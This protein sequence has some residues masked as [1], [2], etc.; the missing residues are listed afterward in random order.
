MKLSF[1]PAIQNLKIQLFK[2]GILITVLFI[3]VSGT[4][5]PA[6]HPPPTN[7]S[8]SSTE[9]DSQKVCLF[10]CFRFKPLFLVFGHHSPWCH[11]VDDTG[12]LGYWNEIFSK[13]AVAFFIFIFIKVAVF[14]KS[15]WFC[16][17]IIS[18]TISSCFLVGAGGLP[19]CWCSV[20]G[21]CSVG[22]IK[23]EFPS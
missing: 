8:F 14:R 2:D 18:E 9:A 10:F 23:L 16:V 1:Y 5:H 22:P 12:Y 19:S 15:S 4:I 20:F 7:V 17:Q 13:A 21:P 6:A 11:Q 3:L